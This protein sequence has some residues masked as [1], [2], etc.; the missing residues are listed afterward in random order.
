LRQLLEREQAA[1]ERDELD[2]VAMD[3]DRRLGECLRRPLLE[4]ASPRQGEERTLIAA[5]DEPELCWSL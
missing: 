4:R 2:D 5:G 3:P 1:V